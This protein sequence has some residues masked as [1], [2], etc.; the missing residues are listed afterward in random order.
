MNC[1]CCVSSMISSSLAISSW[2][3]RVFA[4]ITMSIKFQQLGVDSVISV[5]VR[6]P[7]EVASALTVLAHNDLLIQWPKP[8]WNKTLSYS[9]EEWQALPEQADIAT[10]KGGRR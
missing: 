7:V 3:T 8:K 10:D 4:A 6:K 1:P 5:G 9:K 2:E